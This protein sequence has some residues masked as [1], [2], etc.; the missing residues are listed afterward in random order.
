[1][2]LVVLARVAT[3]ED[4]RDACKHQTHRG[5]SP[6]HARYHRERKG[7]HATAPYNERVP[8][9]TR[10]GMR[11]LGGGAVASESGTL[12]ERR[13]EPQPERTQRT[14][15]KIYGTQAGRDDNGG[16]DS[17]AQD[18]VVR[19]FSGAGAC[20]GTLITPSLVLTA[21]HCIASGPALVQIGPASGA[22]KRQ[23]VTNGA[24]T[25]MSFANSDG[26]FDSNADIA[27]LQLTSPV[28]DIADSRRPMRWDDWHA[29]GTIGDP[30]W[31]F[32]I[33]GWSR[34]ATTWDCPSLAR[35]WLDR[36]RARR[37]ASA[38]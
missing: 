13:V 23:I 18:I 16:G 22:W 9:R 35:T 6:Q 34:F 38:R 1:M 12:D 10:S 33:A 14:Q 26:D 3:A 25:Q 11:K 28:M 5:A 20:S 37:M 19:T 21:A 7:Y 15:S 17:F 24:Q 29:D 31:Q 36:R 27:L 32:G 4:W 30:S 2:L 8:Y